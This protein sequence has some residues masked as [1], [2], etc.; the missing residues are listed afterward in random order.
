MTDR[1]LIH[2][3][4]Q[5]RLRSIGDA[6]MSCT[7]MTSRIDSAINTLRHN[8]LE[9]AAPHDVREIANALRAFWMPISQIGTCPY[10]GLLQTPIRPVSAPDGRQFACVTCFIFHP[11]AVPR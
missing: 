11:G 10:C 4:E 5:L 2:L 7:S 3:L 6:G 9:H 1:E 8:A